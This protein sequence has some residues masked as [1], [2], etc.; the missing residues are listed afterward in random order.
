M[1]KSKLLTFTLPLVAVMFVL[2]AYKY[3][4][5]EVKGKIAAV[6]ET[7]AERYKA[8][9][10]YMNLLAEKPELEK[11]LG[12]L[13]E[14]RKSENSKLVEGQTP[15]IAAAALQETVKGMVT[16]RGGTIA[17]ERILKPEVL[18]KFTVIIISTDV[19]LP[20]VRALSD[21]LYA[22]ETRTPYF[23][24]RELD[25]RVKNF[26]EPKELSAKLDVAALT[27]GR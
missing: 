7:E 15:A 13:K 9:S 27:G 5:L 11:K 26:K 25:V 8:L 16:G 14:E 17:S 10:K 12:A 4:Y 24:V 23:V 22:I 1:K 20:D 6:K 2:V 18:G 3:G 19:T 21:V